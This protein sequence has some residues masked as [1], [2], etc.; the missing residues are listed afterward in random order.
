MIKSECS[1]II[2]LV[3]QLVLMI[4]ISFVSSKS[5]HI[6]SFNLLERFNYIHSKVIYTNAIIGG[7]LFILGQLTIFN[8]SKNIISFYYVKIIIEVLLII[9]LIYQFF[10][11]NK[12]FKIF[13]KNI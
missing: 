1:F 11:L 2:L 8:I 10:N 6:K 5:K 13:N 12:I 7:F 9:L 3:I 4:T